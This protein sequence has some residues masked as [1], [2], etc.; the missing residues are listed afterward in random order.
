MLEKLEIS[1][2][3]LVRN[4]MELQRVKEERNIVH[5][6]RRRKAYWIGHILRRHCL[7][8]RIIEGEIEGRVEVVVR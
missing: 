7:L 6:I 8:K 1:W 2:A 4:E 5:T 3:D